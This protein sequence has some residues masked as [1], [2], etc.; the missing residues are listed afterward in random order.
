MLKRDAIAYFG[1]QQALADALGIKTQSITDWGEIVPELRQLQLQRI[2]GGVLKA[3][4]A[5]LPD[6][7]PAPAQQSAALLAPRRRD[8]MS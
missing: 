2:T 3:D 1:T 7:P 8:Q 5:I 4:P 6:A